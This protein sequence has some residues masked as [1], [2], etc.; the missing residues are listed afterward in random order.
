MT[1]WRAAVVKYREPQR[2]AKTGRMPQNEDS[3]FMYLIIPV[4]GASRTGA[5]MALLEEVEMAMEEKMAAIDEEFRDSDVDDTEN[6]E[7]NEAETISAEGNAIEMA[8]PEIDKPK[9]GTHAV[10]MPTTDAAPTTATPSSPIQEP[11]QGKESKNSSDIE[12]RSPPSGRG[13]KRGAS[14]LFYPNGKLEGPRFARRDAIVPMDS[15]ESMS[16]I[17]VV[18]PEQAEVVKKRESGLFERIKRGIQATIQSPSSQENLLSR[19]TSR[20]G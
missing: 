10:Q 5:L 7:E 14:V 17:S 1:G 8:E 9:D 2:N 16:D 3:H 18:E 13:R 11:S 12:A 20:E 15:D 6:E 19:K 4:S